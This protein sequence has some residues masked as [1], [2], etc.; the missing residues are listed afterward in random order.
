MSVYILACQ[1]DCDKECFCCNYT[2]VCDFIA[3]QPQSY[4]IGVTNTLSVP[5]RPDYLCYRLVVFS[6]NMAVITCERVVR[7]R[8]LLIQMINGDSVEQLT[9]C[10]VEVFYQH[11]ELHF[12]CTALALSSRQVSLTGFMYY[13]FTAA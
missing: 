12:R 5:P 9:V 7:G 3:T 4:D 8:F 10:E 13:T 6:G 11:G 2:S 1:C